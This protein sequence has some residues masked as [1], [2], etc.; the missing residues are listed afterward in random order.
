MSKAFGC[1]ESGVLSAKDGWGKRQCV[2]GC[3]PFQ[4]PPILAASFPDSFLLDWVAELK[5]DH[6]YGGLPKWL[7]AMVA[8]IKDNPWWKDLFRL[9][10]CSMRSWEGGDNGTISWSHCRQPS[11]ASGYEIL[12]IEEAERSSAYHNPCGAI[13]TLQGRGHWWWRGSWWLWWHD[14]GIH[15]SPH[16]SCEGCTARWEMLLSLQQ[17]RSFHQGLSIGEI[18]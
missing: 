10:S 1:P 2:M 3:V 13:S 12:P 5:Q 15:C 4:A 16:Q 9:P 18:S 11:Q 6:F 14:R 17:G 7:K 8:Y